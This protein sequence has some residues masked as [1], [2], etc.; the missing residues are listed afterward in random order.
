MRQIEFLRSLEQ[1]RFTGRLVQTN[2]TG[3]QWTIYLAQGKIAYATG[4]QHSIRRWR[5]N[6]L[7]YCPAIP[8]Y[9][10]AWQID[11][12]KITDDELGLGWEYALLK[13]WV[14]QQRITQQQAQQ[15]IRS[16]ITEILFDL[17]QASNITDQLYREQLLSLFF[18]SAE[19][20][21][22]V[23]GTERSWQIWQ[24][25]GLATYSPNYAPAIQQPEDFQQWVSIHSQQK[26]A[27]LLN[28]QRSL[29]D[30]A[31]AMQQDISDVML[32]LRPCI[33][34]G[35]LKLAPIADLPGLVFKRELPKPVLPINT[36]PKALV[37]CID[38]SLMVRKMMENLL[39]SSGYQFLGIEDPLRA[40][41][42]L[43][44]RKPQFIF[45][46]LVMPNANG[47]EICEKL[48]KL[49]CF[50]NTPIVILTSNDGYANRLRSNF[51]GATDFLS[52][53]LNA[54]MV[55]SMIGKHL[56][57]VEAKL[58]ISTQK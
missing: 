16:A 9:R 40:L 28:G 58:P 29:R 12:A 33:Q 17:M 18:E 14:V 6:L 43:L 46:D 25:A 54:E 22:T 41:G 37:A 31:L 50:R 34:A 11:L 23:A 21:K 24:E 52:K 15:V 8:T 5:R 57:Q 32:S 38:D 39:T 2:T 10:L 19:I 4:G 35:W 27:H 53:P 13:Y 26:L 20:E 7:T 42:I 55:L 1:L 48:R 49:S 51:V 56:T 3:E 30:V 36:A 44:A 45:L 47:Y